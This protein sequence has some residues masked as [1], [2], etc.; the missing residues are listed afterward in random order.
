MTG[1]SRNLVLDGTPDELAV[2]KAGFG[3]LLAGESLTVA[4]LSQRSG[5][6]VVTVAAAVDA[7]LGR[8]SATVADDGR[9]D[10]IAGVTVRPTRHGMTVHGHTANTWCAFDSVGIPAALGLD[11]VAVT[12]CGY[13]KERIE[14]SFTEGRTAATGLW[15]WL[16][17]LPSES[18]TLMSTF[19]S[20]ADL[21]CDREHFDRWYESAGRP[22]GE[23]CPIEELLEIGVA[24]WAHCVS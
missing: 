14:V 23:A 11:A 22:D 9:V 13:C 6:D 18:V 20:A 1:P 16:P 17:A 3:A 24:T 8:E 5:L 19:C 7:L 2:Q 4:E 10:G 21:F 15:G 12:S